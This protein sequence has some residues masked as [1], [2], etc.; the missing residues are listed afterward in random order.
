VKILGV[1]LGVLTAVGGFIEIGDLVFLGQAGSLF[2]YETLWAIV[3]GLVGIMVYSEMAGRVAAVSHRPVFDLVRERLGFGVGAVTLVSGQIV[4]LLTLAAEIGGVAI[5]LQLL[6]DL[7]AQLLIGMAGVAFLV[8]I[9]VLSFEWI[10]RIFSL[11]GLGL[12]VFI[13]AALKMHPNWGSVGQGV[14]PGWDTSEFALYG[15]FAVGI[16]AAMFMPYEIYFY[17]SG[18]IEEG[19]NR[20]DARLNK[21]TVLFGFTLGGVLAAAIL[22]SAGQFLKPAGIQPD[23][24]GSVALSVQ[25]QLGEAGLIIVLIGM[26]FAIGGA[27]AETSLSGAY[28]VAQFFGWEW[29]KYKKPRGAPRFTLTWMI[30]LV[31]GTLIIITGLDAVQVTEFA[32]IFSVVA[33]PFSYLPVLLVANDRTYMDDQVNGPFAN[34]LGWFYLVIIVIA[35]LAAI[36][37]MIITNMGQG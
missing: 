26:L 25:S 30:M 19:W 17:S 23:H 5:V 27:T 34:I 21:A 32:V 12:L 11:G 22:M 7:P 31:L 6:F 1:L 2:G 37:L 3:V 4:T 33:L 10:E 18:G 8:I 9:W 15:Y 29:G 16:I 13:V 36:P 20:S 24:L 14:L 35:A 28:N